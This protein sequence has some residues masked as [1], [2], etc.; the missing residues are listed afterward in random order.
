MTPESNVIIID[1][2][3]IAHSGDSLIKDMWNR[4]Y[5]YKSQYTQQLGMEVSKLLSRAISLN[6]LSHEDIHVIGHSLGAQTAGAVGRD[7][8]ERNRN[9][10]GEVKLKRIVSLDGACPNFS[11]AMR[12]EFIAKFVGRSRYKSLK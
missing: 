8:Q 1:W 7:F 12:A 10:P 5:R 9:Q 6:L 3:D 4:D 2:S 11:N